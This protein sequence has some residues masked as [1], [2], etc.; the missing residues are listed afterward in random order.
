MIM[1]APRFAKV[2]MV[3]AEGDPYAAWYGEAAAQAGLVVTNGSLS[4][5][6]SLEGC[7]LLLLC[8][9]GTLT[10]GQSGFIDQWVQHG[11][12]LMCSGSDWGLSS[13]LGHSEGQP[14]PAM[15]RDSLAD[16][17]SLWPGG[18]ERI[19]FFGGARTHSGEAEVLAQTQSG[20]QGITRHNNAW[21]FAP[22]IGRTF[23]HMLM[24]RAVETDAV[25][26]GDGSAETDDGILRA[27]DGMMLSFEE[28]RQK[29]D[30]AAAPVFDQ[31]FADSLRDLWVRCI[32]QAC[33]ARGVC[34]PILWQWPN[35][36]ESVATT[37]IDCDELEL[38]LL[39]RAGQALSKFGIKATWMVPTPGFSHEAYRALRKTDHGIGLLFSPE[40]EEFCEDQLR[41][42]SLT[43][44]RAAGLATPSC[45]R[46][47]NGQWR[48]STHPYLL[49]EE[50]GY[51]A[52]LSK[53]GR[54]AGT[55]GFLFGTSR[56]FMPRKRGGRAIRVLEIPYA[57]FSPGQATPDAS[58]PHLIEQSV[59]HYGC[60][61]IVHALS[62]VRDEQFERSAQNL[63]LLMRQRGIAM[64]SPQVL[65]DHEF[66][67]RSIVAEFEG[68]RGL[69][70]SS[71]HPLRGLT[72]LTPG[73]TGAITIAGVRTE[74]VPVVRYGQ[75]FTAYSLSMEAKMRQLIQV[76]EAAPAAA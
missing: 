28:D 16:I 18:P 39:A 8:G 76:D 10:P 14:L 40:G 42:Q 64:L 75:Q 63:H 44:A 53:G 11:G 72:V 36:A 59:K 43:I 5:L 1:S 38:E 45:L 17:G 69:R 21:F 25:G 7:D 31:P 50:G 58:V 35:N 60:L 33:A 65:I 32:L 67:R 51:R 61:H 15:A 71:E 73:K 30:S 54:Q 3:T 6:S 46:P 27:E 62:C 9:Q 22:D 23:G 48:G 52:V 56:P 2:F 4:A 13:L 70:L 74:G 66:G 55:A 24:G 68:E 26:P 41:I 49:A 47:V 57:I 29:Q 12:V 20:F 37:S 19:T 34:P